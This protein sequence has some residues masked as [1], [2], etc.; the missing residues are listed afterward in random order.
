M[1]TILHG[2]N[3]AASRKEL[4]KIK[5]EFSG[6][7]VS[8]DGA[9]VSE[10]DYI[11]ATQSGPMFANDRLIIIEGLPKFDLGNPQAEVIVWSGKKITPP[12]TAKALEFRISQTIW[13]FLDYPTVPGF[14]EALRDNDA[15]FIFLMLV[16][17]YRLSQNGPAL[18]KLLEIDYLF[19]TGQLPGD[20]SLAIEL[21]LLGL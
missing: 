21:F 3:S 15:Q 12:K 20:L 8:L 11:Q 10:T 18:K 4:E 5:N 19:K 7:I 13:K 1:I 16:R 14:R 2:E 17:K 6:E 9:T